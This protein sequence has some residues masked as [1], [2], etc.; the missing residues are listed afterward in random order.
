VDGWLDPLVLASGVI[1]ALAVVGF[2][3]WELRCATPLLD[4]R[5]FSDRRFGSAAAAV[6]VLFLADYAVFFLA[7]QYMSYVLGWGPA[8]AGLALLPPVIGTVVAI[9]FV[10]VLT[11]RCGARVAITLALLLCAV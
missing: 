1:G 2:I 8:H 6:F 9:P 4:V 7:N 11:R 3:A 5:L 10:P